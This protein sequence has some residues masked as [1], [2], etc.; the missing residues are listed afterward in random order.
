MITL[1]AA[2]T[3]TTVFKKLLSY[4]V[5]ILNL[6]YSNVVILMRI[7]KE[8]GMVLNKQ[9]SMLLVISLSLNSSVA[10]WTGETNEEIGNLIQ[11]YIREIE[12]LR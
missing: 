1:R 10:L 2:I 7:G 4:L 6:N 9:T 12:E 11:N 8:P 3:V 5:S